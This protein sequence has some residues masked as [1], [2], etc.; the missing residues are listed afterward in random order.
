MNY[1]L[2]TCP[3]SR[4]Q[5]NHTTTKPH[6][7]HPPSQPK[8]L[9]QQPYKRA[10][11]TPIRW[12]PGHLSK[13]ISRPT[14]KAHI[15]SQSTIPFARWWA[16]IRSNTIAQTCTGHTI[17]KK[18]SVPLQWINKALQIPEFG[19]HTFHLVSS[20]IQVKQRRKIITKQKS[21]HI[22]DYRLWMFLKQNVPA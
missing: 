1:S 10:S 8:W 11:P 21:R 20:N 6:H 16:N 19:S 2:H 5:L 15:Q 12:I 18:I 9:G 7:T 22:N 4:A 13:A 17:V 14:I 3:Q